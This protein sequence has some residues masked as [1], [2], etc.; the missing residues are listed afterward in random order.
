MNVR[1]ASFARAF[2]L[3][4][5]CAF[6]AG[7]QAQTIIVPDAGAETTGLNTGVRNAPRT[8]MA[9]YLDPVFAS[10]T[11]PV[12]ITG[13]QLR[14]SID[15]NTTLPATWP[16][17]D[18]SFT[19]YD[20]QL[21]Q[22]TA[23]LI[24][25]GE[26]LSSAVTFAS[27]QEAGTVVNVRSGPLTIATGAYEN[28]GAENPW[29]PVISFTTP[30]LYSPGQS[31]L[32]YIT[33]TGYTPGSEPQPFFAAGDYSPGVTDAISSTVGYQA[34]SASGFSSPY[35]VQFTFTSPVPEPAT[36]LSMASGVLALLVLAAR[37]RRS[38]DTA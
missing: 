27:Q 22:P 1:T 36:A 38:G 2:A 5:L 26:F 20:I 11:S 37:R 7:S 28:T 12:L 24:S 9:L 34:A 16:S 17:Q 13:M 3:S 15:G 31:L 19:N 30:Y 29:G 32:L 6:A 33:H 35:V 10:I 23:S 4:A 8:Y 25:D 21:S 18:I 14:I